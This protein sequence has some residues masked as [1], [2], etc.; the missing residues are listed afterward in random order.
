MNSSIGSLPVRTMNDFVTLMEIKIEGLK[1]HG[2]NGEIEEA[3]RILA[4]AKKHPS[5]EKPPPDLVTKAR[6]LALQTAHFFSRK[7]NVEL[8]KDASR[9]RQLFPCPN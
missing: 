2:A 3:K 8:E 4:E 9:L 6:V 7:C 5:Y 1:N